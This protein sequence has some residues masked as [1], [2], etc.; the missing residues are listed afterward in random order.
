MITG[1]SEPSSQCLHLSSTM[2]MASSSRL[3]LLYLHSGGEKHLEKTTQRSSLLCPTIWSIHIQDKL[4]KGI[5]MRKWERQRFF[6]AYRN[7]WSALG[8]HVKVCLV[9]VRGFV[10]M[11]GYG[12][13]CNRRWCTL[14]G[15]A[16]ASWK[17]RGTT[18]GL[19]RS[20]LCPSSH[21]HPQTWSQERLW[22]FCKS[23]HF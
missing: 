4:S 16:A 18:P 14:E 15:V 11:P 19:I 22:M 17:S 8:V 7:A 10:M 23:S 1:D 5:W 21:I 9:E 13:T 3:H 12:W 20:L 2:L 6:P